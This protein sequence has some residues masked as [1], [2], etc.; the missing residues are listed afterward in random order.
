MQLKPLSTHKDISRFLQQ[1]PN[2]IL[3]QMLPFS[4]YRGYLSIVGMYYYGIN[5]EERK[6][7]SKSLRYVFGDK[8]DKKYFQHILIRTY[9]GILEHY[10]E[11]MINA[12]KSLPEMIAFLN[13]RIL[14]S[15]RNLMDQIISEDRGCILVT[16]HFG[17]VEYIPLYLASN[18]YRPSMILRFKTK[19]LKKALVDKS[20]SVDLELIDADSPNAIVK[21][22]NAIKEKRILIT[23]CDEI[24]SWRPCRREK[25]QIFGHHIPKDRTLDILYKRAKA[26]LCFGIAQRKSTGCDL[27]IHPI[28]NGHEK[29]SVCE[30]SWNL[31]ERYVYRNPEQ[32][33]Q[34]STFYSEFTKYI[35]GME[36]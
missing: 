34:W 13:N 33:Y 30:A 23:L 5:R 17:A 3:A 29:Y 24:Q 6:R 36:C 16:G 26:P 8:L 20:D 22:L 19:E 32:W 2:I 28:T 27:S 7:V 18:H 9:F 14:F 10:F 35:S 12:H 25:A 21:A 11:K 15:G 1:Q 4:I 31:L